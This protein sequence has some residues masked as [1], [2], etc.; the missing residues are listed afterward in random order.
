MNTFK[1]L[2]LCRYFF[3]SWTALNG[4]FLRASLER[5]KYVECRTWYQLTR[6]ECERILIS[7]FGHKVIPKTGEKSTHSWHINLILTLFYGILSGHGSAN[8]PWSCEPNL[9]PHMIMYFFYHRHGQWP[10]HTS[11]PLAVNISNW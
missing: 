4:V 8:L 5:E 2:F 11:D 6:F 3:L 9:F 1:A 10:R 7:K